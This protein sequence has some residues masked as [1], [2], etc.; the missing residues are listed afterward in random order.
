MYLLKHLS[1]GSMD[2][3]GRLRGTYSTRSNA[4]YASTHTL[5]AIISVVHEYIWCFNWFIVAVWV[6]EKNYRSIL[7]YI[8]LATCCRFEL[9]DT[10][11][12]RSIDQSIMLMN[13]MLISSIL[14]PI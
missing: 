14:V 5:R 6:D 7:E 9:C 12:R 11:L 10:G 3:R 1:E 8:H 2:T 13:N 4:V